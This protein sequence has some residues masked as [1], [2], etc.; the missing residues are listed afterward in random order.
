M[1]HDILQAKKS[2]ENMCVVLLEHDGLALFH[3]LATTSIE[4]VSIYMS[5][6]YISADIYL[7]LHQTYKSIEFMKVE[8]L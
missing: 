6:A 2:V 5:F 7:F 4:Y 8:L 3:A 1:E